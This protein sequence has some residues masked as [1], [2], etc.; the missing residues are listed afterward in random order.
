[1]DRDVML[2]SREMFI[3]PYQ[4]RLNFNIVEALNVFVALTSCYWLLQVPPWRCS[5]HPMPFPY[6]RSTHTG[7]EGRP[8]RTARAQPRGVAIGISLSCRGLCWNPRS[9]H[10]IAQRHFVRDPERCSFLRF[11]RC[12][13]LRL[14]G[15]SLRFPGNTMPGALWI[16]SCLPQ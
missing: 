5:R 7:Y 13:L 1:M 8:A 12:N 9:S 4:R 16:L 6:A 10:C 15:T 11:G 14:V 3:Y 2:D